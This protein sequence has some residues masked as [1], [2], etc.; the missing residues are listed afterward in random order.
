MKKITLI[1]INYKNVYI[2]LKYYMLSCIS[3]Q[4]KI[5]TTYTNKLN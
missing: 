2:A 5:A 4:Y 1:R 3:T